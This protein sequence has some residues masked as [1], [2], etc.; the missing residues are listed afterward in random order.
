MKYVL[1]ESDKG[2]KQALIFHDG[3]THSVVGHGVCREHR[4]EG[5]FWKPISAGFTDCQTQTYGRSESL[6]MESDRTDIAYV[7]MGNSVALQNRGTAMNLFRAYLAAK[8]VSH[9]TP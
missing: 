6:E 1:I 2:Q 7:V 8:G 5:E 9:G 4:R 3:L